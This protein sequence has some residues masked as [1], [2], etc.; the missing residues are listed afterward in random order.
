MR[1]LLAAV[2]IVVA[3]VPAGAG[4]ERGPTAGASRYCGTADIGFTS[5]K[6]RARNIGC[7]K[8]RRSFAAAR[9]ARSTATKRTTSAASPTTRAFAA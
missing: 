7:A 6:V 2:A 5:A 8:A 1:S 3:V 9:D 4:A